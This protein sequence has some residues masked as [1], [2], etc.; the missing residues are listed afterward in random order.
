MTIKLKGRYYTQG[1]AQGEFEPGSRNRVLK[2]LLNITHKRK[3]DI[4][5]WEAL[6]HA[7]TNAIHAYDTLH[8]F[9]THDIRKLHHTWLSNIYP[10]ADQYRCVNVA[11]G[12]FHFAAAN[13]IE[14]LMTHLDKKHLKKYTPCNFTNLD[15]IK[16]AIAI[17][18]VELILI[19]P[20]RD[21]NGRVT[22]LIADLMALQAGL[23][24][25]NFAGIKGNKKQEYFRAVQ[26]GMTEN[27]EP[28]ITVFDSIIRQTLKTSH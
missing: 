21:G 15:K 13:Q 26:L 9:T 7:I 24:L 3:M 19:H 18:H 28:M 6:Q 27:Y 10:W 4:K 25:L 16:E 5:E 8:Q 12:N 1:S 17:V 2:N 14:K 22:R 11:K 23:P 20:F